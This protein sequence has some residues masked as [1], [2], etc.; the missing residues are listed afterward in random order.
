MSI[1]GA[2]VTRQA[3]TDV[4]DKPHPAKNGRTGLEIFSKKAI[5]RENSKRTT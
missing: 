2:E 3:V 1:A 5:A 4:R